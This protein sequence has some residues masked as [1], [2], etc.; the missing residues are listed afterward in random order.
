M[1]KIS[2]HAYF[3]ICLFF[4]VAGFFKALSRPEEFP[5]VGS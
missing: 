4:S 3:M 1:Y 5:A 2:V